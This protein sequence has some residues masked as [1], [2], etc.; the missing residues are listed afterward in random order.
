[1]VLDV[2]DSKATYCSVALYKLK[3]SS[4]Y[5]LRSHT[6]RAPNQKSKTEEADSNIKTFI[7]KGTK[8]FKC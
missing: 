1:M 2:T 5:F 3:Y 8:L 4:V 6:I 7:L